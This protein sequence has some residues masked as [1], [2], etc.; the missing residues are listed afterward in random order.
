[1]ENTCA[2]IKLQQGRDYIKIRHM[3]SMSESVCAELTLSH[4]NSYVFYEVAICTTT[5]AF[6]PV[7]LG[8]VFH[9]CIFYNNRTFLHDSLCKIC[10]NC[11]EIRLAEL[12]SFSWSFLKR[13]PG[14]MTV[15]FNRLLRTDSTEPSGSLPLCAQLWSCTKTVRGEP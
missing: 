1:M 14:V 11:R 9:F 2:C 3:I 15:H 5:F 10:R 8:L 4:G 13:S 6:A 7:M 12:K